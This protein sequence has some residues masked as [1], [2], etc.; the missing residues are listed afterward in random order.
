V[1]MFLRRTLHNL[2]LPLKEVA[3]NAPS[4]DHRGVFAHLSPATKAPLIPVAFPATRL[5]AL[6]PATLLSPRI[7]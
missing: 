7:P 3:N 2:P 6:I 4:F 1:T 5:A